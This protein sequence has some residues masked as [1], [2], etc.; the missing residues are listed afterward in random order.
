MRDRG[1]GGVPLLIP[2]KQI[3]TGG[4]GCPFSSREPERGGG[5]GGIPSHPRETDRNRG[6]GANRFSSPRTR[7]RGGEGGTPS[8]PRGPHRERGEGVP[9]SRSPEPP[10]GK[11]VPLDGG[12]GTCPVVLT[13]TKAFPKS[14][15]PAGGGL[16]PLHARCTRGR[17]GVILAFRRS[18]RSGVAVWSI[19]AG[20]VVPAITSGGGPRLC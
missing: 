17:G 12:G 6:E 15:V 16:L 2:E 18:P 10:L 5:E 20:E 11:C 1:G 7:S 9:C 3:E 19:R 13:Q 8:R 4:R 14:C